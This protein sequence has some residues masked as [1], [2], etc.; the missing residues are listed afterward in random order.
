M[1]ELDDEFQDHHS[2]DVGRTGWDFL[3]ATLQSKILL[4]FVLAV[5]ASL[6]IYFFWES[7]TALPIYVISSIFLSLLWYNPICNWL[8]RHSVFI[9]VFEPDNGLLTTYRVGRQ[10]FHEIQ[11][12]GIQNSV[13]SRCGNVRYFASD[14][15]EDDL[16]LNNT[17]V[18][19]CDPWSYHKD[20]RTLSK[21]TERVS[22]VFNDIVDGEAIAQVEGRVKAMEAMRRHYV[23]LDKLFFGLDEEAPPVEVNL[24]ESR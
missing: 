13:P 22:E 10:K 15:S 21:L 3:T 6:I 23:D 20:R 1:N 5:F 19:E 24:D 2:E 7:I 4:F 16:I 9:E 18:H 8:S 17:W 11:K 14:F 12:L